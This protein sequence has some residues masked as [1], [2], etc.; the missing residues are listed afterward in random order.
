M[1]ELASAERLPAAPAASRTAPML[2][3][4]PMQIVATSLV[5]YCIV[6]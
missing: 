6:S 1:R 4:C 2:A 5:M 3:A